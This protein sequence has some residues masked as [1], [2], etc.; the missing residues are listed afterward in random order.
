[1]P[2]ARQSPCWLHFSSRESRKKKKKKVCV[3]ERKQES[4]LE[5]RRLGVWLYY[6]LLGPRIFDKVSPS[7]CHLKKGICQVNWT[8]APRR[9]GDRRHQQKGR[10]RV[11]AA[12]KCRASAQGCARVRR[13]LT[14]RNYWRARQR[15]KEN[16]WRKKGMVRS[17]GEERGCALKP[18]TLLY[19]SLQTWSHQTWFNNLLIHL[20]STF[21]RSCKI[22]AMKEYW[23]GTITG[24][25]NHKEWKNTLK[26]TSFPFLIFTQSFSFHFCKLWKAQGGFA[27]SK[28]L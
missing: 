22:D 21:C 4:L 28:C 7:D 19:Y 6:A 18:L 5:E 12:S 20:I 24:K 16:W 27:T 25:K 23:H 2:Q 8:E 26:I 14:G 1:M 17:L 11:A 9:G 15:R 3:L 13:N 10:G